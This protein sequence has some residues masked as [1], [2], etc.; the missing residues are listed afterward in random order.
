MTVNTA[1]W[2]YHRNQFFKGF[3]I[4]FLYCAK[5]AFCINSG[6]LWKGRHSIR[7]VLHN[8]NEEHSTL[9][10]CHLTPEHTMKSHPC[11]WNEWLHRHTVITMY[12]CFHYKIWKQLLRIKSSNQFRD[13]EI[14]T[15]LR[16]GTRSTVEFSYRPQVFNGFYR[17]EGRSEGTLV[18]WE[19]DIDVLVA[20]SSLSFW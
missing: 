5:R 4:I 8:E 6:L 15:V 14:L 17:G 13:T 16:I 20:I 19:R 2:K 9:K 3:K 10:V 7:N 18:E 11:L 12:H 1:T